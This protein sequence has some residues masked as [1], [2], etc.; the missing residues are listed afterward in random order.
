MFTSEILIEENVIV[1]DYFN[2]KLLLNY[3]I[4]II[5]SNLNVSHAYIINVAQINKHTLCYN[6]L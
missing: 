3:Y 1:K 2:S 4:Q 5:I 6:I